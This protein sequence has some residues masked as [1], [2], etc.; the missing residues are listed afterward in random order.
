MTKEGYVALRRERFVIPSVIVLALGV[1]ACGNRS[2][3]TD[4]A[5]DSATRPATTDASAAIKAGGR[6]VFPEKEFDFGETE[7]DATITHEFKVRNEGREVLHI[8]KVRGS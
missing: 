5:P 7:Q 3:Q 2:R 6:A 4:R 1:A 8:G